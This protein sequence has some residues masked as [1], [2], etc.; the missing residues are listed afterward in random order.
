MLIPPT[1]PFAPPGTD[2]V[3]AMPEE[4]VDRSLDAA[5]AAS[6]DYCGSARLAWRKCK[7]ICE[8]CKQI[9]KSCADL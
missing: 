1:A 9:N 6:C 5:S 3:T 4:R 2:A 7:L 8:N